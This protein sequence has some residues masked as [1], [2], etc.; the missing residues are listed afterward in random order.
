MSEADDTRHR[1]LV[2]MI[3][4]LML[5]QI[6][7]GI[8]GTIIV[9]ALGYIVPELGS[10]EL[11]PWVFVSYSLAS[12]TSTIV[13]GKLSDLYGRR[14]LYY[15]SIVVFVVGAIVCGTATTMGQLIAGRGVQGVGAGGLMTL[16]MIIIAD[17]ISPRERGR[18]QG[19]MG[20]MF[21][22][23]TMLGPWVG[24][25]IVDTTTWRWIFYMNLPLGLVGLAMGLITL[26]DVPFTRRESSIDW[27]GTSTLIV[28]VSA[29]VLVA[30]RGAEWGWGSAITIGLIVASVAGV[31]AFVAIER[32]AA[33][34]VLPLEL[35][36][37][38]V[39]ST[40]S[41]LAFFQGITMFAATALFPLFLQI[42]VGVSATN[43]GLLLAPGSLGM[44]A[45]SIG[46][47]QLIS[48]TGKYR[49]YPIIGAIAT[50]VA[51]I[52][53]GTM[54]TGTSLWEA[55]TYSTLA[56]IGLG[57]GF[58][59]V[60]LAVQNRVDHAHLGAATSASQFFR[61]LGA[62]YGGAILV[63]IYVSRLDYWLRELAGG[64]GLSAA[65]LRDNPTQIREL[66]PAV[67]EAV[68]TSFS[69]SI[70]TALVV[71]LPVA[72][73]SIFIA[74]LVPEYPLRDQA[75]VG[76]PQRHRTAPDDRS[77]VISLDVQPS[78][79]STESVS[80]PTH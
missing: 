11:T 70:T 57:L 37:E 20:A 8:E 2:V 58:Q 45:G 6:M 15:L 7:A 47:G 23:A 66:D 38:P 42:V 65:T 9:N 12:A 62:T 28:W 67:Q 19:Y 53:F 3:V 48:R 56:G 34:P 14:W 4:G 79:D 51:F 52:G 50:S 31:V 46:S 69:R 74:R 60:M 36:R 21:A 17:V 59:T 27:L 43:S 22:V 18:Y 72:I 1:K 49:R 32:R 13:W 40:T 10:V 78:S 29:S 73:V 76:D 30:T 5:A 68:I 63:T 25:I 80:H 75:A 39:F 16:T 64:S 33:E 54:D 41:V 71:M 61:S 24:G 55:V 77:D 44:L 35:F 26:R